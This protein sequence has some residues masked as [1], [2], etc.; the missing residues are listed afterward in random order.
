MLVI[1]VASFLFGVI[2]V[3]LILLRT[4]APVNPRLNKHGG[5]YILSRKKGP[6]V[7]AG[8]RG[9]S[10]YEYGKSAWPMGRKGSVTVTLFDENGHLAEQALHAMHAGTL[11]EAGRLAIGEHLCAC[12]ACFARYTQSLDDECLLASPQPLAPGVAQALESPRVRRREKM[13]GVAACV[14]VGLWLLIMMALPA[15]PA[16]QQIDPLGGSTTEL[17]QV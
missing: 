7:E 2:P 15:P 5:H 13:L 8:R 10:F 1:V 11:D 3:V 9:A 12:E 16:P 17:L 6:C 4:C 14:L